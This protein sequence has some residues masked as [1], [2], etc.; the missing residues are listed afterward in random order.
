MLSNS[1]VTALRRSLAA[2]LACSAALIGGTDVSAQQKSTLE[3]VKSRGTLIAGVRS[4]SRPFGF[5]DSKGELVGFEIEVV[6]YIANKLGVKIEL[7]PVTSATR[8][9]MLQSGQIDL[10]AAAMNITRQREETIDFS[11]PHV[12]VSGKLL[13]KKGS[14]IKD[15]VDLKGKSIAFLQGSPPTT[16]ARIQA[17][18]EGSTIVTLPDAPQAVQAVL[19]GKVAALIMDSAPLMMFAKDHPEK[20]EVVGEAWPPAPEGIGVR[21]ND[22]R[23]R[24]AINFS[25]IDMWKDGTYHKVYREYFGVDPDPSFRVYLWEL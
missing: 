23:W 20:F 3:I 22:S 7:R 15:V 13:V 4:D 16:V 12:V 24:D 10:A 21:E 25:I 17:K 18:A 9:P 1:V 14:D 6:K 8:I 2:V 5:I 19:Q 11:I